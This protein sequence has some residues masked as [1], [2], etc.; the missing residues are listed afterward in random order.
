MQFGFAFPLDRP[1]RRAADLVRLAEDMGF[2]YAWFPDHYFLREVY[3]AQTLAA[4]RT[5]RIQLGTAVTSPYLRH[6]AL[7][8]SAVVTLDEICEGRAIFGLGAG[9]HEFP[10]NLRIPLSRPLTAV[11]ESLAIIRRLLTGEA[12]TYEG[13]IFQVRNA[14][15]P[16][17]TRPDIPLYLAAR[18]RRMIRFSGEVADGLISHGVGLGYLGAMRGLVQEGAASAGR[19][20]GQMAVAIWAS[21]LIS[22]DLAAARAALRADNIILA[23]GEY[24]EDVAAMLGLDMAEVSPLRA[25]VRAGDYGRAAALVTDRIV[26]AFCLAGPRGRCLEQIEAMASAGVTQLIIAAGNNK[27]DEEVRAA[28]ETAGREILPHVR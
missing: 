1:A 24:H 28:I 14:R 17:T 4:L 9:G 2:G 5:S 20:L 25:A 21:L 8:A 27:S 26:D 19:D 18:G 10:A 16:F 12:V 23:G 13:T 22:E 6:P 15:L 7:L 3:A 11:R